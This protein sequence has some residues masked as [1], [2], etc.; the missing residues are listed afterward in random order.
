MGMTVGT[1]RRSCVTS[2]ASPSAHSAELQIFTGPA[3]ICS[4][5][6]RAPMLKVQVWLATDTTSTWNSGDCRTE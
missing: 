6:C 2:D 1:P 3:A 5:T 4:Q